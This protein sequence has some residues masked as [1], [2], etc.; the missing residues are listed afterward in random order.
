MALPSYPTLVA[1]FRCLAS[2]V[3]S[4]SGGGTYTAGDGMALT[5]DAFSVD[6]TVVR[7]TGAQTVSSKAL[8]LITQM[9]LDAASFIQVTASRDLTNADN[10]KILWSNSA[11]N[12]TLTNP[13]TL[14]VPFTCTVEQLGSGIIDFISAV[15][16]NVD[17][18]NKTGGLGAVVGLQ[19]TAG[20]T[21]LLIYG[22]TQA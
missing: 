19:L 18:Q 16:I 15:S 12:L 21:A 2:K 8:Q 13:G 10:G 20:S 3:A 22:R 5:A 14:T 9:T 17:S 1:S 7:T 6:S 4:G 11:S